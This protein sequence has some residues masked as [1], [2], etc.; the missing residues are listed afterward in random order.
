MTPA[1][2]SAL[3]QVP[4]RVIEPEARSLLRAVTGS[5]ILHTSSGLTAL[6]S[7]SSRCS[8]R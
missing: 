2:L 6:A 5:T 4:V 8:G 3:L 1:D 7:A